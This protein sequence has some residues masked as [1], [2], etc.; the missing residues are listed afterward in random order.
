MSSGS[1]QTVIPEGAEEAEGVEEEDNWGVVF[2]L[3]CCS[4]CN[5]AVKSGVAVLVGTD[6]VEAAAAPGPP[7]AVAIIWR[8]WLC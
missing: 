7:T 1:W 2:E 4:C 5:R 8:I 3:A 6:G